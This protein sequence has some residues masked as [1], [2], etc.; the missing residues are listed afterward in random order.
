MFN[1]PVKEIIVNSDSQVVAYSQVTGRTPLI[2]AYV[3]NDIVGSTNTGAL[4]LDGF[5]NEPIWCTSTAA[6]ASTGR[7]GRGSY[8][9]GASGAARLIRTASSAGTTAKVAYAITAASGAKA[10]DTYRVVTDSLDLTPTEYQNRPTE[11]RYQLSVDCA[12]AGAIATELVARINADPKSQVIAYKGFNNASPVQDDSTKIVLVAK[13]VGVSVALYVG[14]FSV[15][16][17]TTYS[18][19]LTKSANGATVYH[20]AEDTSVTTSDA[21]LPVGTYDAL[22]NINWAKNFNIDQNVN[23]MPLPGASYNTYYFEVVSPLAGATT[24]NDA[25][26]NQVNNNQIYGVRLYVRSGL[27]LDTALNLVDGD[28][29]A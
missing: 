3:D 2:Q 25:V 20:T 7:A 22:K 9:N 19:S 15:V 1:I 16:G 23:W 12:N 8:F 14:E 10:G 11:K 27:T 17:Q 24:G 5:L 28:L 18:V 21:V 13:T 6:A 4:I 26:P 29:A